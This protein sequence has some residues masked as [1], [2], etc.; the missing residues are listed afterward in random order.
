MDA[1]SVNDE[2]WT[3]SV[4]EIDFAGEND[5]ILE[6]DGECGKNFCAKC[7]DMSEQQYEVLQRPDCFW[8]CPACVEHLRSKT[9]KTLLSENQ[10]DSIDSMLNKMS[11]EI[12]K[13]LQRFEKKIDDKLN[14]YKAEVPATV[15]KTWADVVKNKNEDILSKQGNVQKIVQETILQQKKEDKSREDREC[16]VIVYNVK[17]SSEPSP[18][19]RKVEDERF[20]EKLCVEALKIHQKLE[21]KNLIRLGKKSEDQGKSRPLKIIMQSKEDKNLVMSNLTKLKDADDMFKR[22][23]VTHDMTLE[24]RDLVK[25]KVQEAKEKEKQHSEGG[26]WIYRVR[27]PP[28]NL[29]IVKLKRQDTA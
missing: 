28:W 21:T 18:G 8:F 4:C 23:S 2:I 29:T 6:C 13:K 12:D 16:N 20:F 14:T 11:E 5:Q 9:S 15:N 17:E 24:E 3:C 1:V 25:K 10:P 22:I 7:I 27:G 19:I 26:Q